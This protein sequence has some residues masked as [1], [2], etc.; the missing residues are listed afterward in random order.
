MRWPAKEY[1]EFPEYEHDTAGARSCPEPTADYLACCWQAGEIVR[2]RCRDLPA[3]ECE[4][5]VAEARDLALRAGGSPHLVLPDTQ[6]EDWLDCDQCRDCFKPA[7]NLRPG[8][9]AQYAVA[10]SNFEEPEDDGSPRRFR[11]GFIAST[12][13]HGARPGTGYKQYARREMTDTRGMAS[14]FWDRMTRWWIWGRQR[15]PQR[16]QTAPE[17]ERGFRGL[18]DV[19]REASFM[20]PG[21]IVAV[22]AP[23]RTRAA[24][25]DALLK[26]EVYGTSGPRILLWFDLLNGPDGRAPMGS[27]VAM[28][29]TPRFEARAVG[30]FEQ[31]PGCPDES[32]DALAP[33]RLERL[34]RG[35][36]YHPGDERRRIEAIEVIRIRPQVRAGEPVAP[37][38]EDPWRRFACA[39]DATGCV[40]RFE[41]PEFAATGRDAVYYVRALEE[42]SPAINGAN[43]RTEFDADGNALRTSPCFG[44]YRTDPDDDCLAPVRE[45]AWSSPI[46]VDARVKQRTSRRSP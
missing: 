19:E 20:Y 41:D 26:R 14:P 13:N 16:A 46:F 21:G 12:D 34:C 4:A 24:I 27:E 5:R 23:D 11:F 7:M 2:G 18:L 33:D 30:S 6:P 36:C 1:R 9:S 8:E 25:W 22:H 17:E 35:E 28:N 37:L 15:D 39:P 40:V 10:I 45:R 3:A 31:R 43:V 38:I 29:E 32:L 44:S 42:P